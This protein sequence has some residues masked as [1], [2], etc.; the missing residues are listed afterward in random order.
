MATNLTVPRADLGTDRKCCV[1]A[2]DPPS[3]CIHQ[4]QFW[5]G[6]EKTNGIDDY[7]EVCADH[8]DTV[9]GEN[10]VVV[11]LADGKRMSGDVQP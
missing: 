7:T 1:S 8:V 2:G 9:L 11:R 3:Q 4:A 5:V 10:D 6:P